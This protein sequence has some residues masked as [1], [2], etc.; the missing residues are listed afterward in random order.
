MRS[1]EINV[2]N[3]DNSATGSENNA[4]KKVLAVYISVFKEELGTY[5]FETVDL[6]LKGEVIP[7]FRKPRPLPFAFKEKVEKELEKLEQAGVIE[8]IDNSKFGTPLVPVVKSNG[9]SLRLCADY[10][11]TINKYLEDFN[12]PLPK[13]E[14][15][16]V[17]LRGGK[18]YTKLDFR[19]AYNQ[20]CL[21]EKTQELLTWSTHM[22]L[23]KV[24]R[25]PYG[26]KP[27]C[28]IF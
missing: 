13:I 27:A 7:I 21:G 8:K 3:I 9:Y 11:S 19:N 12:Y 5:K 25:L 6:P 15:L 23:Y 18:L 4:L 2:N 1:F 26:T 16:F 17:K 28:Q 24:K 14:E 20:L 22:G 10:K